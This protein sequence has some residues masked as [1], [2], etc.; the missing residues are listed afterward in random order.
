M[1]TNAIILAESGN[2][3]LMRGPKADKGDWRK[4]SGMLTNAGV[5]ALTAAKSKD[6]DKL[7]GDVSEQLLMSCEACHA[8]YL[9]KK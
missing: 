4:F 8:K 6:F 2:L 7:S 3:L 9:K 5:A 1:Q